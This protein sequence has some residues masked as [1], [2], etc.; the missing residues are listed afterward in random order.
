M[1]FPLATECSVPFC[2]ECE[3]DVSVCKKC[4]IGYEKKEAQAVCTIIGE[5]PALTSFEIIGTCRTI[6][7]VHHCI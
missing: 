4:L 3:N 6:I 7:M 5:R 2:E 1:E